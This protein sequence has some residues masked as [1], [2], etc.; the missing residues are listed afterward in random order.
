MCL[1]MGV[2]LCAYGGQRTESVLSYHVDPRD[3]LSCHQVCWG[4][5]L[6]TELSFQSEGL[7]FLCSF[8]DL[9]LF[10]SMYCCVCMRVLDPMKLDFQT[11]VS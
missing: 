8:N 4:V 7:F 11:V 6:L 5:S 3:W 10:F 9:F 2:L 1:C